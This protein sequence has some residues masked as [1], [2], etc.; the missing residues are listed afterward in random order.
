MLSRAFGNATLQLLLLGGWWFRIGSLEYIFATRELGDRATQDIDNDD[1]E[2]FS[3][4]ATTTGRFNS[5]LLERRSAPTILSKLLD[6]L[7]APSIF[8]EAQRHSDR[9]ASMILRRDLA[10]DFEFNVRRLT[11]I[12]MRF[13]LL[14]LG[15]PPCIDD[16]E[17]VHQRGDGRLN[18]QLDLVPHLQAQPTMAMCLT[19]EVFKYRSRLDP[20]R[21]WRSTFEI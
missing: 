13:G 2:G 15:R 4:N 17:L 7:Q 19:T 5:A 11:D 14:R 20:V 10:K 21:A 1:D 9:G 18:D 6:G 3:P 8:S 16:Y 12:S